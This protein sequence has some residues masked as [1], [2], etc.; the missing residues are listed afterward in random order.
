MVSRLRASSS[1]LVGEVNQVEAL[2][3]RREPIQLELVDAVKWSACFSMASA[4]GDGHGAVLRRHVVEPVG[5]TQV[6]GAGPVL[7]DDGRIAGDVLV[8]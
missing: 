4:C 7:D 3:H 2:D 1:V 5:H 6:A 8:R